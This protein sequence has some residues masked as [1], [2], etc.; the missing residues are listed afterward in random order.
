MFTTDYPAHFLS[1]VLMYKIET[2]KKTLHFKSLAGTSRGV[3]LQRT[4]WIIKL[5]SDEYPGKCGIGECAPLP[6][7]SCDA[8]PDYEERLNL[9]CRNFEE[10]GAVNYALLMPYPSIAFGLE[11]ALKNLENGERLFDTAFA[12]G[13]VGIPVNGLVWMGTYEEM[14]QRME[15]KVKAGFSC[16]KLKIGAIDFMSEMRLIKSIRDRFS[17]DV[18]EL[19]VDAN[20]AFGAD[21]APRKLEELAKYGIHSI[22]QPIRQRQWD[23]MAVLCRNTPI[24][25]ALDEELIGVNI[26]GMK[27][28]LLDRIKPQYV[29]VKPSL[30]GGMKGTSDWVSL[31]AERGIGS[32]ITSALESNIGLNAISQLASSI[33]GDDITFAQ[34]LGTGSLYLDNVTARTEIRGNKIWTIIR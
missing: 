9:L 5:T 12:R 11:T 15:E 33:Y 20:G 3:Y 13:E 21:D 34:G 17:K 29:V 24:P 4:V 14:K 30:H 7:L 25:I 16:V 6:D 10:T 23:K 26:K 2:E 28:E 22:E 27:E 31:S 32:W 18:I 19:R 1:L 8:I